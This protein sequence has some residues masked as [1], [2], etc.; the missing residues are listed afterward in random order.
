MAKQDKKTNQG[1]EATAVQEFAQE[2]LAGKL[3]AMCVG[4]LEGLKN[5]WNMTSE[6]NQEVVLNKMRE[7]IDKGV[8]NAVLVIATQRRQALHATV[9]GV[10][11]KDGIKAT[12]SLSKAEPGRHELADAEGSTVLLIIANPEQFAGGAEKVQ[13]KPDQNPLPLEE[14]YSICAPTAG[15]KYRVLKDGM[16]IPDAPK[17]FDDHAAAEKWLQDHLEVGKKNKKKD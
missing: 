4:Q 9:E 16:P 6:K 15:F 3:L 2:E 1:K 11:F 13:A 8:H 14:G 10:T 17:G 7:V 12:L 5:P